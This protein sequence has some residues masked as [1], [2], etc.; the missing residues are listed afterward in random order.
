M[1]ITVCIHCIF[2][3]DKLFH[4]F[5]Q[6]FLHKHFYQCSWV[7]MKREDKLAVAYFLFFLRKTKTFKFWWKLK[8]NSNM[9]QSTIFLFKNR[10]CESFELVCVYV[11]VCVCVCM[12][13]YPCAYMGIWMWRSMVDVRHFPWSLSIL[14]LD[15]GLL[16]ESGSHQCG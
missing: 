7:N 8:T 10:K 16:S 3:V 13:V 1:Y 4:N 11:C 5:W 9:I 15:T 2:A 6:C 12:C 14:L